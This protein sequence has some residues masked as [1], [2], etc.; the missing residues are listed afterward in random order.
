MFLLTLL[1]MVRELSFLKLDYIVRL[2][3]L[4]V[5]SSCFRRLLKL[6]VSHVSGNMLE[7]TIWIML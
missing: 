3:V 5:F 2:H 1:F 7:A 4:T 6:V